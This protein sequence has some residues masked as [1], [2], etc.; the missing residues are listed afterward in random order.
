MK[1]FTVCC[2]LCASVA[3]AAAPL[4][5]KA[6]IDAA[7]KIVRD[8]YRKEIGSE[9]GLAKM[10]D[11]A[12]STNDDPAGQAAMYLLVVKQASDDGHLRL[13]FDAV[14]R[15]SQRFEYDALKAK[16]SIV[17]ASVK[18]AKA[19]DARASL[20][21]RCFEL[22]DDAIS[23]SRFD[24]ADDAAKVAAG[25][26]P[27]LKDAEL[28]K[29]FAD[30]RKELDRLKKERDAEARA[31]ADAQAAMR[32]NPNDHK[33]HETIG[34]HYAVAGDWQKAFLYLTNAE[35]DDMREAAHLDIVAGGDAKAQG[36]AAD[37]WWEVADNAAGKAQRAF[38]GRAVYWYSLALPGLTG[39]LKT[40]AEKRIEEAGKVDLAGQSSGDDNRVTILLAPGVPL[41]L[42]K[43][44]ASADG[45]VK[46]FWLGQT[47]VT[48]AQWGAVMG[49]VAKSA[50]LPQT[51]I[52]FDDCLKFLDKLGGNS[53]FTYRIPDR[54]ELQHAAL[55]GQP[56]KEYF[57]H[58]QDYAWLKEEVNERLQPVGKKKPNAFGLFDTLGNVWE[59]CDKATLFGG[60][61][62]SVRDE[63]SGG[64]PL[65]GDETGHRYKT[66][67]LRIAADLR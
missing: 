40:R 56:W 35:S 6:K 64:P 11:A 50:N 37:K 27:R 19:A 46:S 26:V 22:I 10:L 29:A 32:A 5:D 20:V 30:K 58:I 21:N 38:R 52:Y 3:S 59:W 36:A 41:V 1:T 24:V 65:T 55:A 2:L 48:E 67:G 49:G 45:K 66:F 15:L 31:L 63:F 53:R 7:G 9:Q 43:I 33:A 17:S 42:V 8:T 51:E 39:I 12:D 14:D 16:A 28:R 34:L 60:C 4:P 57:E 13:A 62:M 47:E 18:H 23:E 61:A 54:D 25:I 44:P